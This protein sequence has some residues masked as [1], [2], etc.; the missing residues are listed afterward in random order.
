[1]DNGL[2]SGVSAMDVGQKRMDS[3]AANLANVSTPAFKRFTTSTRAFN[4]TQEGREVPGLR[5]EQQIDFSQG[6]LERTGNVTD[7]ALVGDGF[8]AIDAPS[9]ELY[10]RNGA[11]RI[12]EDGV[13]VTNDGYQVVW[14]GSRGQLD[15]V[16]AEITI[17]TSGTVRQGEET[18]GQIK[19]VAFEDPARLTVDR[20]SYYLAPPRLARIDA[21]A[22]VH[23]GALERSN[24]SAVDELVTMIQVQRNFDVASNLMRSIDQTYRRL[25]QQRA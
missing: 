21:S 4:V 2:F 24:V 13:L 20:R 6:I 9:G 14:D 12:N 11:F 7:L 18:V 25:V 8:F 23:Q 19:V 16:G 5:L 17:D 22:E 10:T 3:I 1:V 15:P